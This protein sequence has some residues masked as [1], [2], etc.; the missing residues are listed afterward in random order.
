[1]TRL[2]TVKE[3]KEHAQKMKEIEQKFL[4]AR[5][6]YSLGDITLKKLKEAD[7]KK[8]LEI[9]EYMTSSGIFM[10]FGKLYKKEVVNQAFDYCTGMPL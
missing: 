8:N 3:Q 10:Y 7:K 5:S 9:Q 2:L 4:R 1:M 6:R